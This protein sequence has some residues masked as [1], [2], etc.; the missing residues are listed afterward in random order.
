MQELLSLVRPHLPGAGPLALRRIATGKHNQSWWVEGAAGRWVLRVAPPDS[1]GLLFY[2]RLMMRQEPELHALI[3]ART[4]IPAAIVVAHDF[5]RG[6]ID[7]DW[8]LMTALPGGPLSEA[9][10]LAPAAFARCLRQTGACL[11]QLHRI[12]APQY[13]YLG[14][15][16]PMPPQPDWA[17]AFTLMWNRL[18]DNVVAC[19]AYSEDEAREFRELLD[20]HRRHFERPVP[21]SLLHMDVWAQN[22]LV[23]GAGNLT[24]MVDFD[25]ALWGDP[26]IEFA[27]LDYC[28]ISEPP[29]WEGYGAARD[30]SPAARIRGLFYLLYEVQKYMPI[31]VWRRRDEAR[32]AAYKRQSMQ[33]A[34]ALR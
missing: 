28:G 27:V 33:L 20:R 16:R 10:G 13:G 22:L 9:H 12:A 1:T 21:A 11:A 24:G 3:H 29:F 23:D 7:R 17:S 31:S 19:G 26:E 4:S 18:L 25:R 32:A 14:A 5:T 30:T 34:R 8:L 6:E 15:H 2:E